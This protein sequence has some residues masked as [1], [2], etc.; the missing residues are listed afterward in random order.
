MPWQQAVHRGQHGPVLP[1]WDDDIPLDALILV[2]HSEEDPFATVQG[3]EVF[4]GM[5]AQFRK[6]RC[7]P[8]FRPLFADDERAP[9]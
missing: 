7:R 8:G 5:A 6:S 4:Q 1:V 2:G 9:T 3:V